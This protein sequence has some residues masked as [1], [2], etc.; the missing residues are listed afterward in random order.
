M[1]TCQKEISIN[2]KSASL[3]YWTLD[4]PNPGDN[5]VDKAQG[6]ILTPIVGGGIA[7]PSVDAG[8]YVNGVE[9]NNPVPQSAE[10]Q[11]AQAPN[12]DPKINYQNGQGLTAWGWIRMNA[13]YGIGPIVAPFFIDFYDDALGTNILGE[14]FVTVRNLVTLSA[15]DSAISDIVSVPFAPAV[16]AWTFIAGRYNPTT[17][18]IALRVNNGAWQNGTFALNF[19]TSGFGQM[20]IESSG[21]GANFDATVDEVGFVKKALTDAQVDSIYNGGVGV[22]WP[23]ISALVS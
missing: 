16:G 22:T 21:G 10:L 8:L 1:I 2:V 13:A 12:L 4:E 19:G 15:Q 3:Y 17:G 14:M 5:R 23:A 20:T 18:L 6:V 7:L 9:F 11:S